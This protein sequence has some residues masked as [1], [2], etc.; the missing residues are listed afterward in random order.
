VKYPK[1]LVSD[2]LPYETGKS[3]SDSSHI[4]KQKVNEDGNSSYK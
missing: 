3:A 1:F 2:T 4:T